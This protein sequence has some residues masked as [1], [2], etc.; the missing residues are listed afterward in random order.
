MALPRGLVA[1]QGLTWIG[2][3]APDGAVTPGDRGVF[4]DYD[5]DAG[6]YVVEFGDSMFCCDAA[7][8]RP[9]PR[10]PVPVTRRH[11]AP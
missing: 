2:D 10:P 4:L 7:D 5:G 8:V 1:G 11:N 6:S 3:P 9:D